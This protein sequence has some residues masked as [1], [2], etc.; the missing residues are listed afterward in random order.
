M[1]VSAERLVHTPLPALAWLAGPDGSHA[2]VM[3]QTD[4]KQVLMQDFEP[5]PDTDG[6]TTAARSRPQVMSLQALQQ[7]GWSGQLLLVTSRASV[8]G[9]LARFDFSWF[10]PALVKYR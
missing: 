2:V 3:A 9:A 10:I 5:G 8:M 1:T 7:I 6:K 4:G